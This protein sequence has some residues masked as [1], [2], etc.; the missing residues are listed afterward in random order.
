MAVHHSLSYLDTASKQQLTPFQYPSAHESD[1]Y[2]CYL[3]VLT[4][5]SGHPLRWVETST[6]LTPFLPH[7][8]S[9]TM[10]IDPALADCRLQG[11]A[12]SPSSTTTFSKNVFVRSSK[13]SVDLWSRSG[14][15]RRPQHCERCALPTELRPQ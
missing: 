2:R 1:T 4:E 13:K 15:N 6:S 8:I 5:F 7:S 10:A 9:R 3:P 12:N 14:L 11:T